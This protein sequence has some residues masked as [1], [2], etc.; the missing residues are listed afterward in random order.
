MKMI[1]IFI[2]KNNKT[3]Y[4]YIN[5]DEEKKKFLEIRRIMKLEVNYMN[6]STSLLF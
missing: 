1:Y 2:K 4:I 5:I 6:V 3:K